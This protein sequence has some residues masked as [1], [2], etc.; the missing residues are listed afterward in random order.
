MNKQIQLFLS[1]DDEAALSSALKAVRPHI[2][3]V[4]DSVWATPSP[5]LASSIASCRSPFVF[6]WD[7][8][9]IPSLPFFV[10][11]DGQFEGP[12]N[13]CVVEITRS[14]MKGDLMLSGR[15]AQSLGGP[16]AKLVADMKKFVVD[17][18]KVLKRMT[19]HPIVA[20]NPET[21]EVLRDPVSE[22]HAGDHAIAWAS[23]VPD[24]YFR[25]RSTQNFFK[26]K[27]PA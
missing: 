6:L 13:A 9:I 14:R 18:W 20:V 10:R 23:S 4:D 16:D 21:G 1:T 25:D 22:Y 26:P 27:T 7:Q 3:F 24:H 12:Q 5:V 17:I 11:K 15:I 19:S 2:V 8:S